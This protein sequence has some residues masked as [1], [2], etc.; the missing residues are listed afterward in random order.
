[1]LFIS[2]ITLS[3]KGRNGLCDV[4]IHIH[5]NAFFAF[6]TCKKDLAERALKTAHWVD[7]DPFYNK[8]QFL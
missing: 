1:M 4:S 2:N 3:M 8:N 5:L 6:S 7:D